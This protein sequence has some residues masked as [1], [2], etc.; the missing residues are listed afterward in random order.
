MNGLLIQ[1]PSNLITV[2]R[3]LPVIQRG[4]LLREEEKVSERAE[5]FEYLASLK[6]IQNMHVYILSYLQ[7]RIVHLLEAVEKDLFTEQSAHKQQE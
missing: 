7:L 5:A 1:A 2:R 3:D 4:T 6:M